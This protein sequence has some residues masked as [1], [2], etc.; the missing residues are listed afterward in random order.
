MNKIDESKRVKTNTKESFEISQEI[1]I[2][3]K[4]ALSIKTVI[5]NTEAKLPR[6]D[7]D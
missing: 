7:L 5:L 2:G 4:F 3:S 1:P 6:I